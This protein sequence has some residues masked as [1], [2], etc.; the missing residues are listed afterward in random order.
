MRQPISQE[1][2]GVLLTDDFDPSLITW[3]RLEGR[4]RQVDFEHNL[5]AEIRDP[6]WMLCRQWQLGE[7]QG[8]DAGSAIKAKVQ[9][10]TVKL[11]R[12][13]GRSNQAVSYDNS[14][15]LE[16][17]VEYEPFP[18]DLM[19]QAQVG[20]QWFKL[21]SDISDLTDVDALKENYLVKFGFTDVENMTEEQQAQLRSNRQAWQTFEMLKGRVV[22]GEKLYAVIHFDVT[23]HMNWLV[24]IGIN[25]GSSEFQKILGA[26]KALDSWFSRVYSQ[27]NE[28]DDSAWSDAYLEYQF[29]CSA[30]A[31]NQGEKQTV[32]VAEK[33]HH[34]H[35]DW[36]SVDIDTRLN[37]SLTD[38]PDASV[39]NVELKLEK[40][41]TF[42]SIKGI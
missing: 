4:P 9:V 38:R 30:P 40:P 2:K 7:F 29:A 13:A 39:S 33:Y 12:Y 14:M 24:E 10:S 18:F 28:S 34:G 37:A 32:M 16:T 25:D 26:A 42:I 11:N 36:Y 6:M 27:P 31:D 20:R 22:D 21:L 1:M 23:A 19:T 17:K 8:E 41:I 3:N 15:P 35:L 5:R